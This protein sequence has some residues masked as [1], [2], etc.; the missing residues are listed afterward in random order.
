MDWDAYGSLA[1]FFY[2]LQNIWWYEVKCINDESTPEAFS[3]L[4]DEEIFD[5]NFDF[6]SFEADLIIWFDIA[7][8][9]QMG[10]IYRNNISFFKILLL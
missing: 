10:E 3:F 4:N 9:E 1:G 2:I 8:L 6:S 5:K 7:S